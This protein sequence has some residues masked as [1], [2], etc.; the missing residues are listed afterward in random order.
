MGV[1]GI[2]VIE[3][4]LVVVSLFLMLFP[5]WRIVTKA[6]FSGLWVIALFVPLLNFVAIYVFAFVEWPALSKKNDT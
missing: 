5:F 4:L 3:S 6:G 2:S 1:D